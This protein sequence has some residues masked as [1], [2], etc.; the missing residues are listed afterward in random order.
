[1]GI[2]VNSIVSRTV[3]NV[4]W[5]NNK[6]NGSLGNAWVSYN[7]TT[8]NLSVLLTCG[9]N[10]NFSRNY[11]FSYVEKCIARISYNWFLCSNWIVKVK[12][13]LDYTLV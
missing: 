3:A 4:T 11:S 9:E 1:M 13:K 5:E 8:E 7:S 2:N 10:P 12:P 6:N